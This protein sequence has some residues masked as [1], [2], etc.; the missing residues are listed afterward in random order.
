M[1]EAMVEVM[2]VDFPVDADLPE[3]SLD[4]D[5]P[6]D[7]PGMADSQAVFPV[8]GHIPVHPLAAV[9]GLAAADLLSMRR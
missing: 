2:Q 6:V 3:D 7:L 4:A 1:E 9:E 5:R 8:T